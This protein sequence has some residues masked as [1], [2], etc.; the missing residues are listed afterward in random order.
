MDDG[1]FW[2]DGPAGP[3]G[4]PARA[5]R[6]G[7]PRRRPGGRRA[8]RRRRRGGPRAAARLEARLAARRPGQPA[9][10]L[11]A[12]GRTSA[13]RSRWSSGA[14]PQGNVTLFYYLSLVGFFSLVVGTIVML[15]RPAE[16]AALHFY[17]ICLLFFLMYSTSYTGKLERGRLG[18]VLDRLTSRSCSCPWSSCTSACPSPSGACGAGGPGSSPPPT[19]RRWS[20][21]GAAVASQVLFA[22]PRAAE[23]PVGHHDGDR[24]GQAAL[25]RGLLRASPSRSCSTPTGG[26]AALTA[27]T[28]DEVAG[29]GHRRGRAA[30]SSPSTPCPSRSA[31]SR[32]LAHGAGRL[33]PARPRSRSS[34][35]YAVVKHRLMDVELIFRRALVYVLATAAIVGICPARRSG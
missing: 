7:R 4:G 14:L 27:R 3:R 15:R 25:L 29:V 9:D 17:A 21:A 20:L 35:A 5:G 12:A 33:R 2:K 8:A 18:A 13:A 10:L 23:R 34:L 26:P 31:A 19:C 6:A 16:R 11:A 24:P 32:G 28:P 30:R 22:A 1:V